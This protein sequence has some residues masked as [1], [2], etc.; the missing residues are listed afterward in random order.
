MAR[1]RQLP[2]LSS[3]SILRLRRLL[4]PHSSHQTGIAVLG[5]EQWCARAKLTGSSTEPLSLGFKLLFRITA[6]AGRSNT[7]HPSFVRDMGMG[8]DMEMGGGGY[9]GGGVGSE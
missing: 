9:S 7:S 3:F 5:D 1:V 8:M 2:S 4:H 6:M